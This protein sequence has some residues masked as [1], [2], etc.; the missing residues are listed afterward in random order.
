MDQTLGAVY[1]VSKVAGEACSTIRQTAEEQQWGKKVD[2]LKGFYHEKTGRD[3]D[4]DGKVVGLVAGGLLAI[5]AA[6][7]AVGIVGTGLV[8]GTGAV[9]VSVA[10][11]G[12]GHQDAVGSAVGGAN[13]VVNGAKQVWSSA[14]EGFNEGSTKYKNKKSNNRRRR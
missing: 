10:A 2:E 12:A 6:Q 11:S 3:G 14:V 8:L 1:E 13:K 7:T 4:A 5:K 9:V